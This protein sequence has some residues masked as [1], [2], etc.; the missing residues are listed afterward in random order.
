MATIQKSITRPN[1]ERIPNRT[2]MEIVKGLWRVIEAIFPQIR[3]DLIAAEKQ[4]VLIAVEDLAAGVDIASRPVFV[5]SQWKKIE[6]LAIGQLSQGAPAG[7]DD[8]NTC[9]VAIT[10]DASN[11]IVSKTYNTSVAFP[12]NDYEDL[13]ALNSN[14]KVIV[15]GEHLLLNVTNGATADTPA[16]QLVIEFRLS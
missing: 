16:F 2:T 4:V 10:D 3:D 11:Q 12:T 6:I 15:S 9:V 7:I 5:T 8:A 13:G 1:I 14:N